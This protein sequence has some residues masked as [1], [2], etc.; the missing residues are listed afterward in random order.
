MNSGQHE[1]INVKTEDFTSYIQFVQCID[2]RNISSILSV[3][4]PAVL[5]DILPGL[6]QHEVAFDHDPVVHGT[7]RAKGGLL[8]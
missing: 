5:F 7:V 6:L 2:Y 1:E 3:I 4:Y 8:H